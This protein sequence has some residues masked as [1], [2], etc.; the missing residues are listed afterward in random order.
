MMIKGFVIALIWVYIL[1]SDG[2]MATIPKDVFISSRSKPILS[3][4]EILYDCIAHQHCNGWPLDRVVAGKMWS[5]FP[6]G[7]PANVA[8]AF[9][10]L[11]SHNEGIASFAG[12]VGNDEEGK[13]LVNLLKN[14]GVSTNFVSLSDVFP[15]RQ[16]M[17]TR[18]N[19]G[20]REFAGF[21]DGKCSTTFADC[22][23]APKSDLLS[24]LN[25]YSAVIV[26]TLGLAHGP[27]AE[28]MTEVAKTL[29]DAAEASSPLF[30]VDINWRNAFWQHELQTVARKKILEFSKGADII[31]LTDQEATFLFDVPPERALADPE[32][33][34]NLLE[35]RRGVLVTGGELGASYFL[36]GVGA[37]RQEAYGVDVEETT[38][39]GDAFTA[40]FLT[41]LLAKREEVLS[42]MKW[43][44][45]A[46]DMASG[47]HFATS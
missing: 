12:A 10:K 3:I 11:N 7:A 32:L 23:F 6:G 20:D 44:D 41:V 14:I 27:T 35:A 34:C 18:N 37:G 26:G 28:T 46:L 4:G 42:T 15:T 45:I 21:V 1:V 19:I 5:P 39:A 38:G 24:S 8:C 30:V 31:K 22:Y 47:E 25:C 36:R 9:A 43:A 16:V 2:V 13:K 17:V 33:L 29:K 40:G